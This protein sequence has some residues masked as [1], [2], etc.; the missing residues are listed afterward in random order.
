MPDLIDFSS[1]SLYYIVT[2]TYIPLFAHAFNISLA[3]AVQGQRLP[4]LV[5]SSSLSD[6]VRESHTNCYRVAAVLINM[7]CS[8]RRLGSQAHTTLGRCGGSQQKSHAGRENGDLDEERQDQNE[9]VEGACT[10]S[11]L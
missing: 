1:S 8:K 3:I 7:F 5:F 2:H 6:P 9:W 4:S 10:Y 11:A